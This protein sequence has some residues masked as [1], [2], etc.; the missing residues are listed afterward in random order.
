MN[1]SLLSKV[2]T[3]DNFRV[4]WYHL[5]GKKRF[6][7][8]TCLWWEDLV[9]PHIKTFFSLQGKEENKFKY[10][11]LNYL[12]LKL[13]KQYEISNTLGVID[14]DSI[15]SLKNRI[16]GIRDDMAKGV[17]I[18]T[19]LQD[20]ICGENISNYLISKQK[21]LASNKII[22]S[23]KTENTVELITYKDIQEHATNFYK[24]LYSKS[25]CDIDQQNHFLSHITDSLTDD[26]RAMLSAPLSKK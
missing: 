15:N 17:K 5:R 7:Q 18:R 26:D 25:D 12:E 20:V 2:L 21:E 10:G 8:H 4:L 1:T 3:K 22:T 23:M 13:R 14:K 16:D 24:T 9:K 6:Y 11:T 19:R